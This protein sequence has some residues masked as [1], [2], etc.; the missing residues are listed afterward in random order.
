MKIK[1]TLVSGPVHKV[2]VSYKDLLK[3]LD[4]P[5]GAKVTYIDGSSSTG[6]YVEYQKL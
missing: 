2:H 6:L 4:V 5:K 1:H 3:L